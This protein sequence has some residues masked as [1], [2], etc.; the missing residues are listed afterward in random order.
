M[1]FKRIA[2]KTEASRI[3]FASRN[4][5]FIRPP[6]LS[7]ESAHL[8]VG[9]L[10]DCGIFLLSFWCNIPSKDELSIWDEKNSPPLAKYKNQAWR[11]L[12][13][14][15]CRKQIVSTVGNFD[16]LHLMQCLQIAKMN[17]Q[18]E[19]RKF[20]LLVKMWEEK[21][22]AS[23]CLSSLHGN[24]ASQWLW[25]ELL[26]HHLIFHSGEVFLYF[27]FATWKTKNNRSPK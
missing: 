6:S 10:Q 15:S 18:F 26:S 13:W 19:S 5:L 8:T 9:V 16:G 20:R 1:L 22:F 2:L 24:V 27:L 17:D 12:F 25:E 7:K 4:H 3:Y 23:S 11:R 21:N 14:S